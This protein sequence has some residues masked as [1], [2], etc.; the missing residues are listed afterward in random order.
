[1]NIP[2]LPFDLCFLLLLFSRP[3]LDFYFVGAKIEASAERNI[4][5]V[6]CFFWDCFELNI[7][8]SVF[9]GG[10]DGGF[11]PKL[12]MSYFEMDASSSSCFFGI[13]LLFIFSIFKIFQI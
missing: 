11:S 10:N 9:A 6:I 8:Y 5:L 12:L 1:M 13:Y 3:S 7:F 2:G 4:M